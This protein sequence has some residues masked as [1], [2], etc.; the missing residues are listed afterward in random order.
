VSA[1]KQAAAVLQGLQVV[2]Q[3]LGLAATVAEGINR[4]D[5]AEPVKKILEH[6]GSELRRVA[7]SE[8]ALAAEGNGRPPARSR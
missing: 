5:I 8:A 1:K 2:G 3:L 7:E 6:F 4:Q